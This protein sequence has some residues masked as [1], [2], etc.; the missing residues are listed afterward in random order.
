M[1][2]NTDYKEIDLEYCRA[3]SSLRFANHIIDM[4]IFYILMFCLGMVLGTVSPGLLNIFNN[5]IEGRLISLVFYGIIM[6][7]I[8][9]MSNGRSIGKLITKTK[10]V[11]LDGSD[12]NFGKAFMRNMTRAIPFNAL[13][14]F[15]NPCNPWHDRLSETMVI[16]EKKM[17]LQKQRTSLFSSVK[18][19]QQF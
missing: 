3:G 2:F 9:G 11:N 16:E 6:S 4:I 5:E 7:F 8:E 17:A 13:S 19:N 15:G 1:N 10:A 18:D 14:A 12:L